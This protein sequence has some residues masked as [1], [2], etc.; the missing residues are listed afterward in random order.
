M[1]PLRRMFESKHVLNCEL[2]CEFGNCALA[3]PVDAWK[4]VFIFILMVVDWSFRGSFLSPFLVDLLRK[5]MLG[6]LDGRGC[7]Q[8]CA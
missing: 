2:K 4:A 7:I 5:G 3:N 8:R 1:N 6:S